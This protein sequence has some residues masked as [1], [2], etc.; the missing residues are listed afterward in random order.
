MS[1]K[2][3]NKKYWATELAENLLEQIEKQPRQK[4]IEVLT[5]ALVRTSNRKLVNQEPIPC[6][7]SK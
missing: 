1:G 5:I 7:P 2:M 6:P 3:S 4:Q